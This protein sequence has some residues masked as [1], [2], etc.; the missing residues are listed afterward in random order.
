MRILIVHNHYGAGA[1]G[2]EMM[3]M[4][5][6]VA[7]LR[8]HG[9]E[10]L[11]YERYNSEI[12]ALPLTKRLRRIFQIP[13]SRDAQ[14]EIIPIL[15]DFRP[16]VMHVHNYKFMLTPSI[17]EAAKKRGIATVLT[18]HN[19]RLMVPCAMYLDDRLRPCERCEDGKYYRYLFHRCG[20]TDFF[21]RIVSYFSF[22]GGL[23]CH[24]LKEIVDGYVALSEFAK[25]KLIQIGI[26][27]E[28]I[29]VKPNF[30]EDPH[31]DI[32]PEIL[33]VR[34]GGIFIG[35]LSPEKGI[36][37]LLEA[38]RKRAEPLTIV[39][40]GPLED[41]LKHRYAGNPSIRFYGVASHERCLE[42]LRQHRYFIFPSTW[43]EGFPM[44]LLEA[45]ATGVPCIASD[46]GVRREMIVNGK[47]GF[48]Y[49][50]DDTAALT[51]QIAK[52]EEL[53]DQEYRKMC[54]NAYE[55]FVHRYTPEINY[56]IL[57]D[58]YHKLLKKKHKE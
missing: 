45:L 26:P 18:L 8:K 51:A 38:W 28:Q 9:C 4:A 11:V 37:F 43:F 33:S 47:N 57:L 1:V 5:N 20:G 10:V 17:F 23:R 46:L 54:L 44:T 24:H 39:G 16:D 35:R 22:L 34:Q 50:Y 13:W 21:H 56:G 52:I 58:I 6:E 3:V 41:V 55:S 40:T 30:M 42:L 12:S 48:L 2:G 14:Q 31:P 27:L 29:F 49:P 36:E 25:R 32:S 15:D 53:S 7:L 19:Y